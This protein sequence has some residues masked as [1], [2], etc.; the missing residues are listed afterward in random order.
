L[1]KEI[2][3]TVERMNV[4]E[5]FLVFPVAALHFPVVTRSKGADG[6]V[7]DA[8]G[9][10]CSFKEIRFWNGTPP[11]LVREFQPI[12]GLN[13][14]DRDPVLSVEID[15]S[16]KKDGG[17]VRALFLESHQEAQSGKLINGGVLVESFSRQAV[18]AA[19]GRNEL[20]IELEFFTRKG[21]RGIRFGFVEVRGWLSDQMHSPHHAVKADNVSD[22]AS[23]P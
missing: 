1:I 19:G 17:R 21:H 14:T 9:G 18:G 5:S 13:T 20:D 2:L 11:K 16:Q 4:V 10:G 23:V 8:K 12:I 15:G 22:I 3:E 7:C 6:F